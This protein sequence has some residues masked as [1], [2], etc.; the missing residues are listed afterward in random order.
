MAKPF[1]GE[2]DKPQVREFT[3]ELD[4]PIARALPEDVDVREMALREVTEQARE[5]EEKPLI[6]QLELAAPPR[7][8]AKAA[9]PVAAGTAAMALGP[10]G[11]AIPALATQA[12]LGATGATLGEVGR[13]QI[14]GEEVDVGEAFEEGAQFGAGAFAGGML[15]KG[16]ANLARRAFVRPIS[17]EAREAAEFAAERNIPFLGEPR[18]KGG[19]LTLGGEALVRNQ[20]TKVN[21]AINRTMGEF[22]QNIKSLD[23]ADE[24][25]DL[26]VTTG[27]KIFDEALEPGMKGIQGPLQ[28]VRTSLGDDA[29]IPLTNTQNALN[30]ASE[31]LKGQGITSGSIAQKINA[32]KKTLTD[33]DVRALDDL[34]ELYGDFWRL[35]N[36]KT[37]RSAR[38]AVEMVTKSIVDDIDDAA[39]LTGYQTREG[40]GFA[41]DFAQALAKREDF[42]KLMAE[43]PELKKLGKIS[44]EK[45]RLWL[46]SLFTSGGKTLKEFRTSNPE[47][48]TDLSNA[49]LARNMW[50]N[51][52][53]PPSGF[54]RVV[55]GK[56]LQDW[57]SANKQTLGEVFGKEKANV[58]D[59]FS[60]FAASSA[61]VVED[62]AKAPVSPTD[63]LA[64]GGVE[65]AAVVTQ[66]LVAI[67]AE[68]ASLMLA[69][70]LTNPNSW[71]FKVLTQGVKTKGLE[72]SL[73]AGGGV[74]L[75]EQ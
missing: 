7:E 41:D 53:T 29:T 13:Q 28:R 74:L 30:R 39:K 62:V 57:V 65:A 37:N 64:R 11:L 18:L 44:P 63:L 35:W 61:K 46:N 42:R 66:P 68:G 10:A 49:W 27:R 38:K 45:T 12:G 59:Q 21:A 58:I 17:G 71:L 32:I 43:N 22:T 9:L 69:Y 23:A 33:G 15:F 5:I 50:N 4:F 54:G 2:L 55:D 48:Y 25:V 6:R 34:D 70:G 67:P 40:L 36:T 26:A 75:S 16:M 72:L 20:A 73:K 31:W 3:G 24:A 47:V 8:A 1:T 56:K 14:E 52:T 60:K 51:T 19:R